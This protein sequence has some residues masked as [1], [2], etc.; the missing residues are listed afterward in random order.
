[1]DIL[2]SIVLIPIWVLRD[3]GLC[4]LRLCIAVAKVLDY[5]QKLNRIITMMNAINY[6]RFFID[7]R[8][9]FGASCSERVRS[10]FVIASAARTDLRLYLYSKHW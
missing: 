5:S 6:P 9:C 10:Y 3:I 1:M 2:V 4:G 7:N 8:R